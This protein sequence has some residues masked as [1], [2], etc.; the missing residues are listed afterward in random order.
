MGAIALL[1]PRGQGTLN[2][3]YLKWKKMEITVG[4]ASPTVIGD[5]LYVVDDSAGLSRLT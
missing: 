4:R 3:S 1:D 5:N 2:E